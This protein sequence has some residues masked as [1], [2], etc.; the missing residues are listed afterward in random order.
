[1][2]VLVGGE[3]DGNGEVLRGVRVRFVLGGELDGDES[4]DEAC[5]ILRERAAQLGA[6][7]VDAGEAGARKREA[8]GMDYTNVVV[9]TSAAGPVYMAALQ[10]CAS[11][12]EVVTPAWLD[13][14]ESSGRRQRFDAFRLRPLEGLKVCV[15]GLNEQEDRD[16][17]PGHINALGAEY[18]KDMR[19]GQCT[20]LIAKAPSG[21]KYKHALQWGGVHIVS[22][23]WLIDVM[24]HGLRQEEDQYA[25]TDDTGAPRSRAP[26][27]GVAEALAAAAARARAAAA[28]GAHSSAG[29]PSSRRASVDAPAAAG[30]GARASGGGACAAGAP[31]TSAPA[32]SSGSLAAARSGKTACASACE[33]DGDRGDDE[34]ESFFLGWVR[35]SLVGCNGTETKEVVR[36][37]CESGAMREP[38]LH[39]ATTHVLVGSDATTFQLASVRDHMLACPHTRA[40]RLAWLQHCVIRRVHVE[41]EGIGMALTVAQLPS[42]AQ[43]LA[44]GHGR[45][46]SALGRVAST[47]GGAAQLADEASR[48]H[49]HEPNGST[50]GSG[51]HGGLGTWAGDGASNHGF[52]ADRAPDRLFAGMWFTTLAVDGTEDETAALRLIRAKGGMVFTAS[53]ARVV[54]DHG[55]AFAICPHGLPD[56][57]RQQLEKSEDFRLVP[58]LQR[59]TLYWLDMSSQ[60]DTILPFA[61]RQAPAFRPLPFLLPI[62]AF[63][64]VRVHAT[65]YDNARKAAIRK[66]VSILGACYTDTL[67]KANSHLIIPESTGPK[68]KLA[69]KLGIPAVTAVWLTESAYR[70]QPLDPDGFGPREGPDGDGGGAGVSTQAVPS[71][72]GQTQVPGGAGTQLLLA[73]S[74]GGAGGMAMRP[75]VPL[76]RGMAGGGGSSQGARG[77]GLQASL[78]ARISASSAPGADMPSPRPSQPTASATVSMMPGAADASAATGGGGGG[79]SRGGGIA[80]DPAAAPSMSM[81]PPLPRPPPPRA[82]PTATG[83]ALALVSMGSAGDGSG[84][85]C[86]GS[87]ATGATGVSEE[88]VGTGAMVLGSADDNHAVIAEIHSLMHAVG[89]S[90]RGGRGGGAGGL[91]DPGCTQADA[92]PPSGSA[93]LLASRGADSNGSGRRVGGGRA[94]A[95]RSGQGRDGSSA[96]A[97]GGRNLDDDAGM[98]GHGEMSQAIGYDLGGGPAPAERLTRTRSRS[99]SIEGAGGS[100]GSRGSGGDAS[101]KAQIISRITGG[102]AGGGRGAHAR[103]TSPAAPGGLDGLI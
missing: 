45:G 93:L 95:A 76:P 80:A 74:L 16:S 36:L 47:H 23:Q 14:C 55:K 83:G 29:R 71:Q 61:A 2:G 21:E 18:Y 13:E 73:P 7:V 50:T 77:G 31:H 85:G 56:E 43:P 53:N 102:L 57:R 38:Q 82:A 96:P 52:G 3:S 41:A 92:P 42:S 68:M 94:R 88:P 97:L 91:P 69:R 72:M 99:G 103:G 27:R 54:R 79:G 66:L 1:M 22:A 44:G 84:G 37:C 32:G 8:A 28:S 87:A 86:D 6:F 46:G 9:T 5:R 90:G 101:T 63:E 64:G 20:H 26:V 19:R 39:R 67:S 4:P 98:L 58:S 100:G 62:R 40:V 65:T 75:P 15:T 70:G 35:I 81:P 12:P 17:L 30:G 49:S 34:E 59:V 48:P 78:L 60:E 25:L 10:A 11:R 89:G 24:V 51:M 33:P